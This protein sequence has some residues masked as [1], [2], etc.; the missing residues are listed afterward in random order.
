VAT[1]IP[2]SDHAAIEAQVLA[3]TEELL[4]ELGNGAGTQGLKG[5]AR[6]DSDLGLGSIERGELLSR[7]ERSLAISMP[8]SAVAEAATVSDIVVAVV[9]ST[10]NRSGGSEQAPIVVS[11]GREQNSGAIGSSL[12]LGPA[13][14]RSEEFAGS[15]PVVSRERMGFAWRVLETTYGLYAAAVFIVWLLITW[16]VVL[17]VPRGQRAARMTSAALRVYFG[18]I[19]CQIRL[20]GREHVEGYGACIYVSNHTSYSDVPVVMACFQTNYHFVAKSE[21]NEMLIVGTFLR[22][23]GHFAFERSKLRARSRQAEE[24]EKALIRGESIFV[25]AEGTFR[26]EPGVRPF[27]L[28]AFRAAVR[29]G[30]PIVPVA[31]RGTRRF[32]RDGSWLPKPTRISVIVRPGLFATRD[33]DGREWEAVLRLRDETRRIISGHAGEPLLHTATQPASQEAATSSSPL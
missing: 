26:A 24:I 9:K 3:I 18:L 15:S 2:R 14:T 1:L 29:T 16:L 27:Q 31:L 21:I 11:P 32:L 33:S 22:R 6:L 13:G 7:L 8:E 12:R 30:R 20:E 17:L 5:S 10:G 25:F 28:G 4:R 23:L 19:G